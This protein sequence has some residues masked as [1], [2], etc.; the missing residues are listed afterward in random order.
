MLHSKLAKSRRISLSLEE[1]EE[2]EE[3]VLLGQ[4]NLFDRR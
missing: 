2:E 4:E 3:E 1:E